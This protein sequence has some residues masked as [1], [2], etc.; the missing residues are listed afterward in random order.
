MNEDNYR[1]VETQNEDFKLVLQFPKQ[2]TT[3]DEYTKLEVKQLLSDIL[4]EHVAK[5]M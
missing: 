2:V 4:K 1:Q 3:N 5:A